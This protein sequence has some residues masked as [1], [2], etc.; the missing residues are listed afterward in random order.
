M[1]RNPWLRFGIGLLVGAFALAAMAPARATTTCSATLTNL[2]FGNVSPGGALVNATATLNYSCTY[3]GGLLGG[4]YGV[5]V[6]MCFS[7]GTG[8]QSSGY[9]PRQMTSTPGDTMTFQLYRDAARSLIWGSVD[10]ATYAAF[11]QDLS[12]TILANGTSQGG[13]VT[14]YGQVPAGQTN[15]GVG[16]YNDVFS[17]THTKLSYN[18]NEALLSLGTFPATCGNANLGSFPF[19]ASA[20][21]PPYCKL[22]G[23]TDL[24]FGTVPGLIGTAIDKVS[25]ISMNCT[26]R[27]SWQLGLDYGQHAL[28]AQRRMLRG[29]G[30][31]IN[32]GLYSDSARS[33]AWGNTLG[34]DTVTGSGSGTSQSATVYGRVP[35]Q[36]AVPAGSYAD[37][38]TVTVTY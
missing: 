33:V 24:D 8:V 36:A 17:G 32:Y 22:A 21:V 11:Q 31:T 34:T 20:T 28:G 15:I 35:A 1:K 37:I 13:S 26:A 3:N 5:Y 6:R 38:V 7:I 16:T 27:T 14:V 30:G 23:A 2:A 25:T 18:Y 9:N 4:L 19:T 29:A 12:F 10:N